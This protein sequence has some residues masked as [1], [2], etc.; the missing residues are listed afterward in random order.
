[1]FDAEVATLRHAL[2]TADH[3]GVRR[4]YPKALCECV[5]A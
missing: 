4:G 1:M 2:R 5:V 3:F